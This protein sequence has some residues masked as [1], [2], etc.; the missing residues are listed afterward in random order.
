MPFSNSSIFEFSNSQRLFDLL[1][2][3]AWKF[4]YYEIAII[5]HEELTFINS[6]I[7]GPTLHL[8][9]QPSSTSNLSCLF[10]LNKLFYVYF[11]KLC[12]KNSIHQTRCTFNHAK[13]NV[14]L[15][16]LACKIS[17][18]L[19]GNS[20]VNSIPISSLSVRLMESF[21]FLLRDTF[22]FSILSVS[23]KINY[24]MKYYKIAD[25]YTQPWDFPSFRRS[26]NLIKYLF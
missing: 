5:K 22:D 3:K 21:L 18:I 16:T 8:D 10:H 23:F 17:I 26:L 9:E 13:Y 14:L 4:H 7:E 11:T 25:L 19:S 12:I 24:L 2:R 15:L 1:V 20:N 6:A